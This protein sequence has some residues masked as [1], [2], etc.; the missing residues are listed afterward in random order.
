VPDGS[1]KNNLA[2]WHPF[3]GHLWPIL[4][5]KILEIV[6]LLLR[7]CSIG[8]AKSD[9]HKK[10]PPPHSSQTCY[11]ETKPSISSEKVRI[12]EFY[13]GLDLHSNNIHAEGERN[14]DAEEQSP[15]NALV[16]LRAYLSRA[17]GGSIRHGVRRVNRLKADLDRSREV[18]ELSIFCEY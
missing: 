12:M 2:F 7:L 1:R 10:A 11:A 4:N 13:C 8:A 17:K 15:V 9:N 6:L 14:V 3:S 18:E 16:H 5:R